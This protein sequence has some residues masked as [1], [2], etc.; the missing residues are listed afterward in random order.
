MKFTTRDEAHE[1]PEGCTDVYWVVEYDT[2]RQDRWERIRYDEGWY[3]TDSRGGILE[4]YPAGDETGGGTLP[5][6]QIPIHRIAEVTRYPQ[7]E[8]P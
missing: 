3:V 6:R 8:T 2:A 1:R 7:V 5:R 4:I